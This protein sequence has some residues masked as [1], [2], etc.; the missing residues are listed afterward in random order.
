MRSKIQL[1]GSGLI[2]VVIGAGIIFIV[3]SGLVSALRLFVHSG[4]ATTEKL[5]AALLVEEGVEAMRSIRDRSWSE[6]NGLS[7]GTYHLVLGSSWSATT[8]VQ[9]I[10]SRF[11]R[12]F[13][14][15]SVYRRNSDSDIVASTSPDQKTLDPNTKRVV[16]TI[17]W[18]EIAD[19]KLSFTSGTID[20]DLAGFPSNNA[21]N[22]DAAQSFTTGAA[23]VSVNRADLYIKKASGTP[24]DVYLELRSGSAVGPVLATSATVLSAALPDALTWTEFEFPGDVALS[25][26]TE[27]F[28]RLRSSPDSTVAFSGSSGTLHLGYGQSGSSPYS[29]GDAYRYVGRLGNASDTG[30]ELTQYDFSFRL[31]HE[32]GGQVLKAVTYFTNLFE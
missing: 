19:E 1:R 15:E 28:L 7:G 5:Q 31:S 13:T 2:E 6:F 23:A 18:R 21:G 3:L 22:G 16:V 17:S 27:Y 8:T 4:S 11:T 9:L 26:N 30:E 25:A 29:G 10:D 12:V 32:S 20:G 24:S 14:V